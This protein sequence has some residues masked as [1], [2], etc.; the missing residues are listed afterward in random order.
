MEETSFLK[1]CSNFQVTLATIMKV[2]FKLK[3]RKHK[4]FVAN[5]CQESPG[6]LEIK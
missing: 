3:L 5:V 1:D 2:Y 6:D 4:P